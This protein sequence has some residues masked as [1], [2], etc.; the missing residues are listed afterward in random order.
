VEEGR[1]DA[2][3][4]G[5]LSGEGGT[6][7]P[8]LSGY[9]VGMGL[10]GGAGLGAGGGGGGGVVGAGLDTSGWVGRRILCEV[11]GARARTPVGIGFPNL[12]P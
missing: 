1:R 4:W 9:A 3:L 12:R 5:L 7:L 6:G 2:G 10:G 8:D 11:W